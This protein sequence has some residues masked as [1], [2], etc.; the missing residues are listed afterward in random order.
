[1]FKNFYQLYLRFHKWSKNEN[2]LN[3]QLTICELPT[4]TTSFLDNLKSNLRNNSIIFMLLKTMTFE[5][6][7]FNFSEYDG[8]SVVISSFSQPF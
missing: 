1:M 8:K 2:T 6:M 4:P 3:M 7:G 5:F